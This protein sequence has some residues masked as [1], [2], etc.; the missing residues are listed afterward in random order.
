MNA[1]KQRILRPSDTRWL[2]LQHCVARILDQWDVLKLLFLQAQI[3]DR[4]LSA[5]HI[6]SEF[7]NPFTKAYLEFMRFVLGY[8]NSINALFQ[9]K[10]NL[11]GVFQKEI[12]RTVRFLCQNFIKPQYLHDAS[13]IDPSNTNQL[14]PLSEVFLGKNCSDIIADGGLN[15]G[16]VTNFKKRC[17]SF[18]QIA[19]EEIKRMLPLN[20]PFF[21]EL[22]FIETTVALDINSRNRLPSLGLL[23]DKYNH[24]L[25]GDIDEEWRKLPL[26]FDN[27][28]IKDLMK[29]SNTE[30]WVFLATVKD[31]NDEPV[32]KN[33]VALAKFV[34]TLPH[35]NAETERIFSFLTDTKTKKAK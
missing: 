24:L 29:K 15:S 19:F 7:N 12:Q 2:A 32:F 1:E 11:I 31:V 23:K 9:S 17:L 6:V 4:N 18:Y 5:D 35:S 16:D 34:F 20:D 25:H 21:R 27:S 33:L 3:E 8:F 10:K 22:E 30:F 26:Y 14:L 13:K 28:E